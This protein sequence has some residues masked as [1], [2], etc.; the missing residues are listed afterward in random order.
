M[1]R[2]AISETIDALRRA[3]ERAGV[4]A[5]DLDR[6]APR[7]R[8][9]ADPARGRAGVERTRTPG[10]SRRAPEA[11]DRARAPRSPP[12]DSGAEESTRGVPERTLAAV[13][14]AQCAPNGCRDRAHSDALRAA[15][16]GREF[17]TT[18]ATASGAARARAERAGRIS[19]A[20][21]PLA[22]AGR[23]A[24]RFRRVGRRRRCV[25]D[26]CKQRREREHRGVAR[27]DAGK[28]ARDASTPETNGDS[29]TPAFD[30]TSESG[31]CAFITE[32]A[33]DGDRYVANYV[34]EGFDPLIF[35]DG[36]QGTPDDKHVHF[37]FNTTE[38]ANAGTNGSPP[39]V[40]TIWD[41]LPG[42][43]ELRFDDLTVADA[44]DA[45]QMCVLVADLSTASKQTA[46][47]AWTFPTGSRNNERDSSRRRPRYHVDR[48]RD[49]TRAD[50]SS[51]YC[52]AANTAAMPS[53][54]AVDGDTVIVGEAAEHQ[55]LA[56][57][58]SGIRESK[59]RLGD[60]APMVMAGQPYGAE[61][62]DG[63]RVAPRRRRRDRATAARSTKSCS[64]TPRRGAS[65][66]SICCAKRAGS[67]AWAR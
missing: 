4:R 41:R 47:T 46:A 31:R 36:E 39:G 22:R 59:R 15:G 50:G 26:Q 3:I 14:R 19:A 67:P 20:A 29:Q 10:R 48:G 21:A 54:V 53:V 13:R 32:L 66:S 52:S 65:T 2:A 17:A 33:L 45:T 8:F 63:S 43:G 56:D 25:S 61:A 11:L 42:G 57:P 9:V 1:I 62:A 7:R 18:T 60:T 27:R 44:G 23:L 64:R 6:G 55:L 34:T 28:H 30:C 40:W 12:Q 49:P 51:C 38:P 35:V 16:R 5:D 37:F 58:A 24:R